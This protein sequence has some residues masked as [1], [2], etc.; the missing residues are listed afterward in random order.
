MP[1]VVAS[2]LLAAVSLVAVLF[3]AGHRVAWF[4]AALA[5]APLPLVMLR[6]KLWPVA[7]TSEFL[8]LHLLLSAVGV[9]LAGQGMYN[10]F[11]TSWELYRDFAGAVLSAVYP[12]AIT[13]PGLVAIFCALLFL[14]YLFW[15]SRY[16]RYADS[17][18]DVGSKMP[19]FVVRD[20]DGKRIRSAELLGAP[21]VVLFYRGNWCPLCMA[22]IGELVERY[23]DLERLGVSVCLISPQPD[24]ATRALAERHEVPFRYLVDQDNEAARALGIAVANGVPRGVGGDYSADTVMPTLFVTTAGGTIVFSDQTD[25]Y[26]VRPEPDIFL[27]ILRRAR[28]VAA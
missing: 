25:N 10:N 11:V 16:G 14:M 5:A 4:G 8:P 28:A 22:Q 13:M 6:L 18:L 27:A 26:R 24:E 7:R 2:A 20:L 9:V 17:R 3:A 15:Y 12:T 19:D 23:Q 1:A 21:T